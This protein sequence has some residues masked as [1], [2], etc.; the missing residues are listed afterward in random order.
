MLPTNTTID[1]LRESFFDNP[2]NGPAEDPHATTRDRRTPRLSDSG[3][4][5]SQF[6]FSESSYNKPGG[7]GPTVCV[8]AG[9]RRGGR[10][11]AAV[12][13]VHF[14]SRSTAISTLPFSFLERHVGR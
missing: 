12:R 2:P 10:R 5:H 14:L 9:G 6:T 13:A 11:R 8:V 1:F 4:T 3:P 7:S